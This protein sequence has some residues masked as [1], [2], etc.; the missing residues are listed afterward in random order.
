MDPFKGIQNLIR[1]VVDVEQ[2]MR[3][4]FITGVEALSMQDS[5]HYGLGHS[6]FGNSYDY[7]SSLHIVLLEL[8]LAY[9]SKV[10]EAFQGANKSSVSTCKLPNY[11]S[12]KVLA[13]ASLKLD[14]LFLP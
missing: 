9:H 11:F 13:K 12:F 4:I 8:E 3:G 2:T 6:A 5:S 7:I 14:A 1:V 10:F